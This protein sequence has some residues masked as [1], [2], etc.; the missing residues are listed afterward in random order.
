MDYWIYESTYFYRKDLLNDFLNKSVVPGG[1]TS[2]PP[3]PEIYKILNTPHS[4]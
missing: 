4:F 3:V 1:D 2:I